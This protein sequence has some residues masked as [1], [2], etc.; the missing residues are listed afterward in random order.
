MNILKL[1]TS[2]AINILFKNILYLHKYTVYFISKNL[3]IMK[4]RKKIIL[5][6]I[7]VLAI[8]LVC[9]SRHSIPGL[10]GGTVRLDKKRRASSH[11]TPVGDNIK[12]KYKTTK[13]KQSTDR[14][15]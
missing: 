1:K 14:L 12:T 7:P 15:Y 4:L 6:L 5:F 3:K 13:G 10:D 2:G 11:A 9:C 8:I